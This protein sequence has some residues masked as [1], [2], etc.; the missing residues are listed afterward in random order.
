MLFRVRAW[1]H[2]P[3]HPKDVSRMGQ[4]ST[5][6]H[7][8]LEQCI[9][10]GCRPVLQLGAER[11]RTCAAE[12]ERRGEDKFLANKWGNGVLSWVKREVLRSRARNGRQRVHCVTRDMPRSTYSG[13]FGLPGSSC[14]FLKTSENVW[15]DRHD[16]A[17]QGENLLAAGTSSKN[18]S[19]SVSYNSCMAALWVLS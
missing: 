17:R 2:H 16:V 4:V 18:P 13:A 14:Q 8:R 15:C 6:S 3:G 1:K 7:Q 5:G 11:N 19:F 9:E 12:A 10:D